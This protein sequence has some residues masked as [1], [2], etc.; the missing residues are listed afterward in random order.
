MKVIR[1]QI[2]QD[3]LLACPDSTHLA[4]RRSLRGVNLGY[5]STDAMLDTAPVAAKIREVIRQ[6]PGILSEVDETADYVFIATTAPQS[7]DYEYVLPI[8]EFTCSF[9]YKMRLVAMPA[10]SEEYQC[11]RYWSGIKCVRRATE[12]EIAMVAP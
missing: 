8:G 11:G 1:F 6:A 3:A 7:Y 5:D 10:K 4:I 2:N 12:A 9:G